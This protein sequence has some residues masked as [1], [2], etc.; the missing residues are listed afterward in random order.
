[1]NTKSNNKYLKIWQDHCRTVQEAT[2]S[3]LEDPVE[4]QKRISRLLRSYGEFV[5]YYFPHYAK[6]ECAPFQVKSANKIRK[7]PNIRDVEEW[8]RGHAKSTHFDIMIPMWLKA[9]GELKV[10]VLVGKSEDNADKLLSDLQAELQY[11]GKYI[12]DF[13]EQMKSGSWEEGEFVTVD[14]CLF[15]ALGRGQSPRGLRYRA[16][17]PDYIVLDDVDDDEIVRNQARMNK[18]ED[19]VLEALLGAL[20]MGRGRFIAVGNR[21]HK[22]S[23]IARLAKRKGIHHTVVNALDREGNP[24]WAAKYTKAEILEHIEFMGYRRSQKEYFNNPIESGTVF[25]ADWIVWDKLPPLSKMEQ[26]IAYCDP[27]FKS[28]S[29]NDYKAIKVWGKC[30]KNLYL[31]RAFVRQCSIGEMVRWWYDFHESLPSNV[32]CRYYMEANFMQDMILDEF[33]AEAAVRGYHLP[34]TPDKRQKPDKFQR[35]EALSPLYERGFVI[36]NVAEKENRDMETAVEQL[37]AFEKGSH[38]HDDSP[39][40]DEGAIWM[41]QKYGRVQGFEPVIGRQKAPR[42][43]W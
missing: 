12:N 1:M 31:A 5:S 17:R 38:V 39:D 8:A 42:A 33:D 11:N 35:I 26:L 9:L 29:K 28:S 41:L 25:R 20:D 6:C 3:V 18:L 15:I 16:N 2:V 34:I 32:V 10:M 22:N 4:K 23:L 40:A 19:W 37:L 43:I 27:S 14:E 36:Y 7:T 30:G 21:I 24:S 13:G